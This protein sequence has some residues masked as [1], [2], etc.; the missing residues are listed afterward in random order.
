MSSEVSGGMRR[1]QAIGLVG[2][3]LGAASGAVPATALAQ[4]GMGGGKA[5]NGAYPY[6]LPPTGHYNTFA[7]GFIGAGIYWD[8]LE[9]P[10]GMYYWAKGSWMPLMATSWETMPDRNMFQVKLRQG[11]KWSDGSAFG[12]KDVV[13][14]FLLQKLLNNVVWRYVD[15]IETPDDYTVNF[16]MG[17]PTTIVERYVLRTQIRSSATYGPWA[18]KV[19]DLVNAGKTADSDE[20]KALRKDFSEFRPKAMITSGPFA[21]DPRS[22][23]EAQ[24]TLT[25]VSSSWAAPTVGFD[26]VVLYNGE[27]P[28]ISSVVLSKEVDYATHGFPPATER[29]FKDLGFRILRPP[30]YG[31]PALF[32]NYAKMP[33]IAPKAVRQAIAHAIKREIGAAAALGESA[34]PPKY[35]TGFSDRLVSKWMTPDAIAKLNSYEYNPAGAEALMT[36]AGYKKGSDGVWVSPDG[37]RMEYEV[38]VPAEFADNSALA[39]AVAEQLTTFGIKTT[40]R[41]ITFTQLTPD[42]QAGNFQMVIQGWGSGNPHPHF[43]FVADLF[44]W[45]TPAGAGPGMAYP[46]IQKVD[47]LG[48]EVDLDAMITASAQ[49]LDVDAQKDLIGKL[50]LA[51]NELLPNIP[52]Y[53]RLGNNPAPEGI[54]VKGWPAVGDPIFDNSPYADSFTIMLILDGTLKPA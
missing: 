17:K 2:A 16:I 47:A 4:Y 52:Q 39:Q 19:R 50:A 9:M 36:G 54:R 12:S 7:T 51:Y 41:L 6:D 14:T 23:T 26:S 13:N 10:L 28:T 32:F 22:M 40:V 43:A 15:S 5:F 18:N 30:T 44:T 42:T 1:R 24:L 35:M 20:W 38:T 53:E 48:G 46:L 27:T 11:A 31:G 21:I 8:L 49:G 45:N 37:E 29:A 25:K 33:A 34:E 3:I